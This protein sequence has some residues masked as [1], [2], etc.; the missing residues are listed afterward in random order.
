MVLPKLKNE[1][2]NYSDYLSWNDDKRWEII[3]G[4]VYDMSP[5]PNTK[6]QLLLIAISSAF[7]KKYQNKK[8]NVFPAPFDVRLSKPGASDEEV[9][10]IL[11]PDISVICNPMILDERGAKGAPDLVIEILSESTIK[12]DFGIKLLLYQKYGVKEYWIVDPIAD[13]V[14][15]YFLNENGLFDLI[16]IYEAN[17]ILKPCIFSELEINL[18]EIFE[19]AKF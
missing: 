6:H 5:A 18:T 1:R 11:Q 16:K 13:T 15:V 2:Y 8:C 17:E 12:K 4:F 9:E 7:Y 3:D 19:S 14:N 10:N